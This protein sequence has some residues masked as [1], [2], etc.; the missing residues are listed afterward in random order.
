M[1]LY[2]NELIRNSVQ[3]AAPRN[4]DTHTSLIK[5]FKE[6]FTIKRTHI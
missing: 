5:K 2:E 4:I 3:V 1:E 6:P